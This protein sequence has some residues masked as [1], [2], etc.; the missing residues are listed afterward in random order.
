[1]GAMDDELKKLSEAAEKAAKAEQDAMSAAEK[2]NNDLLS[3]YNE[4]T[5]ELQEQAQQSNKA[6]EEA[7]L[8]YIDMIGSWENA[9]RQ[10]SQKLQ[11]E[12][13]AKNKKE[14]SA[15]KAGGLAGAAS[16]I[17]NLIGTAK[18]AHNQHQENFISNWQSRAD[19]ARR[20]RDARLGSYRDQLR[21]LESQR[22]LL[23]Y[24]FA[25]GKAAADANLASL[26]AQ[27]GDA[28]AQLKAAGVKEAAIGKAKIAAGESARATQVYNAALRA[29]QAAATATK[30][31][32]QT[33]IKAQEAAARIN[34]EYSKQLANG[35]DSRTGKFYNPQ[36]KKYDSDSFVTVPGKEDKSF[37]DFNASDW[38]GFRDTYAKHVGLKNGYKSYFELKKDK[39]YNKWVSE[40]PE[41]AQVL[42]WLESP[43][44]LEKSDLEKLLIMQ[45]VVDALSGEKTG[46]VGVDPSSIP[47]A[48]MDA[49][50]RFIGRAGAL[51]RGN[52]I[53]DIEY[54]DEGKVKLPKRLY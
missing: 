6:T 22:A 19:A 43:L 18:G 3:E 21:T 41:E 47:G 9:M 8:S 37:S 42:E 12:A 51:E 39:N 16:A 4:R 29:K 27:R 13:E 38:R 36:T 28:A 49:S 45:S 7:G 50:K 25:K 44:D 30:D 53:K 46:R 11:E 35:Y 26:L 15:M 33:Q 31:A 48:T 40:H 17:I 54:D 52:P 20:E 34:T 23:K 1:M 32:L 10:H 14:Q 24:N 2:A 5:K